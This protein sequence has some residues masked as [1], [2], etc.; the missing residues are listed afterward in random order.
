LE[1]RDVD[2]PGLAVHAPTS[3]V[4]PQELLPYLTAAGRPLVITF[5]VYYAVKAAVFLLATV[6]AICTR[7][8]KRREACVQIVEAVS[9][10]WPLPRLP[11]IRA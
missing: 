8:E 5:T 1:T 10:G 7:D 6:V 9:R 11:G 3:A 2:L 4:I